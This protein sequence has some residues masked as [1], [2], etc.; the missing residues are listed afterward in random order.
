MKFKLLILTLFFVLSP[1]SPSYAGSGH[2]HGH[3]HGNAASISNKKA[4]I[5]AN[6]N[7]LSIVKQKIE[8]NGSK[9]DSSWDNLPSSSKAIYKKSD[10]YYI[11]SLENKT[12][13]KTLY[14]LLSSQG[15]FRDANY[16][17]KFEGVK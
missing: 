8:I 1:I 6:D 10:S 11:V 7:V 3:G 5:A 12:I 15:K 14:V 2:D 16:S 9:L 13:D 17:G 4:I